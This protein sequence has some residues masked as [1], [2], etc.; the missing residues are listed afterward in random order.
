MSK[1]RKNTP[2][3]HWVWALTVLGLLAAS[4]GCG[5][6]AGNGVERAGKQVFRYNESAAITSLDPA[7]ARSLEHMWVVDQLYDGLVELNADLEVVPCVAKSWEVDPVTHT[8]T[9]HLR[10]GV[11]FSSGRSVDASDVVF[12]LERLRDPSVVSSG[13]W[14][15]DA[16]V[17]EGIR[18]VDD[19]TVT[20]QLSQAYPPFLGLLTT[21]YGAIVDRVHAQTEGVSLRNQPGGTG[22]FVLKWWLED[23]GLVLHPNPGYWERDEEDNPLPYLDAVHIDVVQDMGSEFLGLTQGR[24]DFISGL[25]PSFMETLLDQEGGLR[26]SFAGELRLEHVPFLK[27]DYLGVVLDGSQTPPALKNPMVRQALSL[28]L[29]RPSLVKHLR[30]N[31]VSATDRFV[32]PSMLG[33]PA[34]HPVRLEVDSAKAMLADAGYADGKGVGTVVVSTTSDYADL[35]AAIQHD[36][37]ALGLDVQIDV[38]PSSV[39]RER[40]AQGEVAVFYKSWLADHPDAENFLGLFV[41]ANFSPGGPNYTHHHN[42]E[43]ENMYWQALMLSDDELGRRALYLAM[44][45]LVHSEMPVIP[46]FHDRVTHV[47]REDVEGWAISPVNRLDLRRV[48]KGA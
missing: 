30:R 11:A 23:A 20:I 17:P 13:G 40:V 3:V 47:L 5:L 18:A 24:Y 27:T 46:L 44:D 48:K 14:I 2:L 39:L 25:H 1:K 4:A 36:W 21:A 26:S 38:L 8:Y 32:P 37:T 28:A 43:F 9:F 33:R 42:P 16:V 34:P 29:D 45:S 19:S 41:K 10:P 7:A 12:S 22:P 6:G 31:S 15:L 35:C